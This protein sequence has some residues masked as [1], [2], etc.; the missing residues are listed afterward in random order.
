M[1][2]AVKKLSGVFSS[3]AALALALGAVSVQSACVCWFHQPEIPNSM[4]KF[5]K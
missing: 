5:A 3:I 4:K 2:R 1:M